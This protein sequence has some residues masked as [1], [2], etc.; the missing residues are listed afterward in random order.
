[1][2]V[3]VITSP[4][5]TIIK[6][7]FCPACNCSYCICNSYHY[8]VHPVPIIDWSA[9]LRAVLTLCKYGIDTMAPVERTKWMA[10]T[11]D[12]T[13]D[14]SCVHWA[15]RP[16]MDLL[17]CPYLHCGA[18]LDSISQAFATSHSTPLTSRPRILTSCPPIPFTTLAQNWCSPSK[19]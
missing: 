18:S 2:I 9:F 3:C 1:M 5:S 10:S 15:S 8:T 16:T 12:C 13:L 19:K 11:W 17:W 7:F 14:H 4:V 6:N